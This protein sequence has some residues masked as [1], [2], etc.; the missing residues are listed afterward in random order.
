MKTVKKNETFISIFIL[1]LGVI[2]VFGKFLLP[3]NEMVL[4]KGMEDLATYYAWSRKFGFEELVKGHLALWNPYLFC[5]MP[6]LGNLQAAL[7][8]PL[9]WFFTFFSLPM[10]INF[11]IALH[12]FLMGFFTYLWVRKLSLS[13]LSSLLAGLMMMF[14]AAFFLRITPGHL[15]NLGAMPWIALILFSIEAY[16]SDQNVRW[17]FLGSLSVALE[18]L[19]GQ[20]QLFYYCIIFLTTY[21]VFVSLEN[22]KKFHFL[23]GVFCMEL[24]GICLGAIQLLAGWDAAKDELRGG[25]L[26]LDIAN[27]TNLIPER[28]WGM[29][30]PNF[31]GGLADY[32]GASIYW[33]GVIFI[34]LTGFV[35]AVSGM[36]GS[37]HPRKYFFG[38]AFLFLILLAVGTRTPL[39][40][41]FYKYF[42]LFSHFRGIAKL[43]IFISL[44][45]VVLAAMGF[46]AIQEYPKMLKKLEKGLKITLGFIFVL[47]FSFFLLS[48][49]KGKVFLKFSSHWL[50]MEESVAF[51]GGTLLGLLFISIFSQ[52]WRW[53]RYGFIVLAM[54]ELFIFVF[55]N[56]PSF[57]FRNS[58][59]DIFAIEKIYQDDPG[60]YRI[61]VDSANDALGAR[62]WDA[63]GYDSNIPGRY[64][65]FLAAVEGKDPNTAFFDRFDLTRISPALG[66]TRLRYVLQPDQSGWKIQKLNLNVIPRVLVTDHWV[67][68]NYQDILNRT[69][70]LDFD[71][72][73]EILLE[74][75]PGLL[76]S[77]KRLISQVE[78]TDINSDEM[79]IDAKVSKSA[80]LLIGDNY[81]R[82]W[83]GRALPGSSQEDYR[84][85]PADGFMRA[86]PLQAGN[87]HILLEYR[88]AMFMLGC[89][90]SGISWVLFIGC[91]FLTVFLGRRPKEFIIV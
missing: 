23:T 78:L 30:M 10:A 21:A 36:C 79:S 8:Y 13:F 50:G 45:L 85:L 89:W 14:G 18:I 90:I 19:S 59:Q 24:A 28:L 29:I 39:F 57:D 40:L 27:S 11:F 34:S 54:L 75:D 61:S 42:P 41:L 16:K 17:I 31:F 12:T 4:S 69:V 88:P 25:G 60:N 80:V 76:P 26:L 64:G 74:S 44:C 52:K 51:C 65:R 15:I 86:I 9:N 22:R 68:L 1:S 56:R 48:W 67:V 87:H 47:G 38:A 6:F 91:F 58:L 43:D 63:A 20:M 77:N 73:R 66:L 35:L 70:K 84:I 81:S 71:P 49:V 5:G 46:D 83:K 37:H 2:V 7:L 72:R 33:E 55:N 3:G 53:V 62:K 82:G 32:W